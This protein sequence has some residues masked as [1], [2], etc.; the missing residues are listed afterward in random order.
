MSFSFFYK[1]SLKDS[2]R[3]SFI[4]KYT[5][6]KMFRSNPETLKASIG[7]RVTSVMEAESNTCDYLHVP[8]IQQ[9]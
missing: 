2:E 7:K 6:Y 3:C 4:A 1:S 9:H 5:D 8:D